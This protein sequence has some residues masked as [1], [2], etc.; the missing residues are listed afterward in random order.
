MRWLVAPVAIAAPTQ[1][2]YGPAGLFA[3]IAI[4]VVFAALAALRVVARDRA[5]A[6][7]CDRYRQ[8][9]RALRSA[10]E[11]NPCERRGVSA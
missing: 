1:H 7:S 11:P 2:W 3:A 9:R 10:C 5:D 8:Q 4:T 6:R